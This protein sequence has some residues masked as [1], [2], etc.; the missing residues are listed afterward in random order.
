MPMFIVLGRFTDEGAKNVSAHMSVVEKNI[1]RGESLGIK[2]H[3][4]Y[5]TQG[6]YDQIVVAEAPDEETLM[7]QAFGVAGG[8]ML[9]TE[10]LRAFTLD[11]VRQLLA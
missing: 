2:L 11:E 5:M 8:G 7:K 6:Q 4:W 10:T 9:R 3:G 1:A